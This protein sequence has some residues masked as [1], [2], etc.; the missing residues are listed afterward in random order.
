M[1][2]C[3]SGMCQTTELSALSLL[4][5]QILNITLGSQTRSEIVPTAVDDYKVG[6]L[7]PHRERDLV[8]AKPFM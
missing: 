8:N 6:C 1:T 7:L 4:T 5:R 3:L 2:H